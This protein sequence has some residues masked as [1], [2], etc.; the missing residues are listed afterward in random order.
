M[1]ETFNI[2]ISLEGLFDQEEDEETPN[3]KPENNIHK[4][5]SKIGI[6][7]QETITEIN[8]YLFY[9]TSLIKNNTHTLDN[10]RGWYNYASAI[11]CSSGIKTPHFDFF[12]YK[13][14][15]NYCDT[16]MNVEIGKLVCV[17][18]VFFNVNLTIRQIK[19]VKSDKLTQ[20]HTRQF[21]CTLEILIELF[22]LIITVSQSLRKTNLIAI[23]NFNIDW[24]TTKKLILKQIVINRN[25]INT[26][27][28]KYLLNNS[29][30][31]PDDSITIYLESKQN[32][33]NSKLNIN[34]FLHK[35]NEL[36]HKSKIEMVLTE[37]NN[38]FAKIKK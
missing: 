38:L 23:R 5:Y 8:E 13:Y 19:T 10:E 11:L 4:K 18:E 26:I 25:I 31:S 9:C 37:L 30:C 28:Y 3:Q 21:Y 36:L 29:N 27:D 15:Y 35:L 17:G 24:F 14:F 34:K 16:R 2:R 20:L 32:D 6:L 7:L 1:L 12:L 22:E 33:Q